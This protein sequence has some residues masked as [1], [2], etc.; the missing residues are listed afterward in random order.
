MAENATITTAVTG[1]YVPTTSTVAGADTIDASI[2][3][4]PAS[5]SL[6]ELQA[7]LA[8]LREDNEKLKKA[9][10]NASADAS[11]YKQALKERMTEQER[12]ANETKELIEQ[13]KAENAQMKQNQT[14]AEYTN[15]YMSLGFDS[16]LAKKAAEATVNVGSDFTTLTSTIKEFITARDKAMQADALRNTPRP[17]IGATTPAVSKEQFDK[18]SYSERLKLFNEQPEVYQNLNK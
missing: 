2:T 8:K 1:T 4:T 11:K 10:T 15:G 6:A 9:T 16:V 13:L 14:I 7:E 5:P 17:G 18:M 3:N 12:A